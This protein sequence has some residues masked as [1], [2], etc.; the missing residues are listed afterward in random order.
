M[1]DKTSIFPVYGCDI[2]GYKILLT[3]CTCVLG[4][5]CALLE[6]LSSVEEIG[7]KLIKIIGNFF[8]NIDPNARLTFATAAVWPLQKVNW[9][10]P[11]S[12]AVAN[13]S[14]ALYYS[15]LKVYSESTA[16]RIL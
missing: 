7:S 14:V 3:H 8:R 11:A 2:N 10:I 1:V 6:V 12:A 13:V 4:S 16:F 5:I 15:V 9:E